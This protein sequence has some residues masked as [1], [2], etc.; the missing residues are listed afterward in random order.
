[1]IDTLRLN[2][3]R[4]QEVEFTSN[5]WIK[6]KRLKDEYWLYVVD[7]ALGEGKIYTY[8]NPVERFKDKVKASN[9][10]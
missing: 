3:S 4:L 2:H 8:Q 5:E 10:L 7:D 1:M 6:A 9:R